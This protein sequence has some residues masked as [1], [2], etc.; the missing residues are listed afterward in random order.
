ML[1]IYI[2]S[3]GLADLPAR[4]AELARPRAA[5]AWPAILL[6]AFLAFYVFIGFEDMVNVAE[7]VKAPDRFRSRS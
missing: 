7:E 5:G 6:G 2:A 3:A 1:I 4:W